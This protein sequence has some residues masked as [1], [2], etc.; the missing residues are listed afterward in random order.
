MFLFLGSKVSILTYVLFGDVPGAM[1]P[2][3]MTLIPMETMPDRL[4][5]TANGLIMGFGE[6][7]GG[8]IYPIIAGHIADAKGHPFMMLV[9]AIMLAVDIF[10]GFLLIETNKNVLAKRKALAVA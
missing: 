7:I 9:A 5:A 1:S 3:F 2:L 4:R 6:V 10:L 8:S